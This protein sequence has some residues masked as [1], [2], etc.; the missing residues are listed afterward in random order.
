MSSIDL[1]AA[2]VLPCEM[3]SMIKTARTTMSRT[4]ATGNTRWNRAEAR[5]KP[6][7]NI[8]GNAIGIM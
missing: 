6:N 7:G 4:T 8:N 3:A 1:N 5:T 2:L